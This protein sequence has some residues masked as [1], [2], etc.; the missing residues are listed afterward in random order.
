MLPIFLGMSMKMSRI[1][2]LSSPLQPLPRTLGSAP[3]LQD[4]PLSTCKPR[5]SSCHCEGEEVG[6]KNQGAFATVSIGIWDR[7]CHGAYTC[8]NASTLQDT[9]VHTVTAPGEDQRRGTLLWARGRGRF[10]AGCSAT[11]LLPPAVSP[12]PNRNKQG[13]ERTRHLTELQEWRIDH[14]MVHI[15]PST[16]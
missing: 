4:S 10:R 7:K 11:P 6:S 1:P 14:E 2:I 5:A 13:E 9:G 15:P 8:N 3:K 16:L 12:S